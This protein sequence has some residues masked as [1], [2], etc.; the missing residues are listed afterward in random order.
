MGGQSRGKR[1]LSRRDAAARARRDTRERREER[2]RLA[3]G[4]EGKCTEHYT[5]M[6]VTSA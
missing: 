4:E 5:A 2:E 3:R 6:A 1:G